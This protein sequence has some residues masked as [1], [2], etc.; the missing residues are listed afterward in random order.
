M[1]SE[2]QA[3]WITA[4]AAVVQ[5]FGSIAALAVAFWIAHSSAVRAS[6]VESAALAREEAARAASAAREEAIQKAADNRVRRAEVDHH[7]GI[8]NQVDGLL[9]LGANDLRVLIATFQGDTIRA[10][11]NNIGQFRSV[12]LQNILNIL[13]ELRLRTNDPG[14]LTALAKVGV[15]LYPVQHSH[16]ADIG[17]NV[18]IKLRE[19]ESKLAAIHEELDALRRS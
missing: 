6:K 3:A 2:L 12:H 15:D 11:Q 17:P 1:T 9:S 13:P 7:N 18:V 16:Y 8:I 14:L 5:A 10:R 19:L 4:D